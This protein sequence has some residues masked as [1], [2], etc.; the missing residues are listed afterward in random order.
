MVGEKPNVLIQ[1]LIRLPFYLLALF[2]M[3]PYYWMVLGAFKPLPE[4]VKNP[5]T[6]IIENPTLDNFYNPRWN[7]DEFNPNEVQGF[8]QRFQDYNLPLGMGTF[9]FNSLFVTVAITVLTVL[10]ASAIAYVLVKH[11][12]PG[13]KLVFW[14]IIGSMML[15]WQVT[16]IP[17]FL[18]VKD[19]GWM[20]T[21]WALIIPALANAYTVFFLR[22]SISQMP[23]ELFDAARID[24]AGELRIWWQIVLPLLRP[25]IAA[26]AI[27]IALANWNNFLWPLIVLESPSTYTLPMIIKE[28]SINSNDPRGAGVVMVATL[29]SSIPAFIFF[30]F[31]QR[32]FV[33]GIA[34]GAVK[35]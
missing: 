25:A 35:G 4:L 31:F 5:P 18:I 3:L 27:F 12:F 23:E 13:S 11:P 15:P 34:V 1:Q 29:L 30:L 20:N 24:G 32:Q 16:L 7:P 17:G 6:F 9:F 21:F 26:M 10:L 28:L 19:L 8:F 2:V 14:L 22:Q 33:Q